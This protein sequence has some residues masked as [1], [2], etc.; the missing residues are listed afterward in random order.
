MKLHWKAEKKNYIWL[1]VMA[2][3]AVGMLLAARYPV[4]VLPAFVGLF[5][6]ISCTEA[7]LSDKI[8]WIW[9]GLIIIG[10]SIFTEK[11]IQMVILDPEF[12]KILKSDMRTKNTLLVLAVYLVL[13]A[14]LSRPALAAIA[15]DV[16]DGVDA[17]VLHGLFRLYLP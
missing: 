10:G 4:W 1:G 14:L 17:H 5:F 12:N 13:H 7:E 16:D 6:L 15:A 8:P 2:V 11:C 3:L 9:S